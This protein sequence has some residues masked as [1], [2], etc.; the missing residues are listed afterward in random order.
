[1]RLHSLYLSL[2][3]SLLQ[4]QL[5]NLRRCR[6]TSFLIYIFASGAKEKAVTRCLKANSFLSDDA[7]AA[8]HSIIAVQRRARDVSVGRVL[9]LVLDA[10]IVDVDVEVVVSGVVLPASDVR[11]HVVVD[12]PADLILHRP[13]RGRRLPQRSSVGQKIVLRYPVQGRLR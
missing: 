9:F 13:G 5:K 10:T 6:D 12:A 7:S 2:E 8:E 4:N 1:M 11:P 3:L